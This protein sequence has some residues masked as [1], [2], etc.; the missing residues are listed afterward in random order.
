MKERERIE[1]NITLRREG[2]N[3]EIREGDKGL[4]KSV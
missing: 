4:R 1:I 3:N 2:E